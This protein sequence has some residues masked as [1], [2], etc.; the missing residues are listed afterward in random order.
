MT[1]FSYGVHVEQ[2]GLRKALQGKCDR[3]LNATARTVII[4]KWAIFA[5]TRKNGFIDVAH[6]I[7]TIYE[8]ILLWLGIFVWY[9]FTRCEIGRRR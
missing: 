9:N 7:D 4:A 6:L 8:Q 1:A 2:V 5:S 3:K